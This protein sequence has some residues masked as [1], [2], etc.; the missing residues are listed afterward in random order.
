MLLIR[1]AAFDATIL[2]QRAPSGRRC[3]ISP[4]PCILQVESASSPF[5]ASVSRPCVHP[6]S[7]FKSFRLSTCNSMRLSSSLRTV[8]CNLIRSSTRVLSLDLNFSVVVSI[9][10]CFF[11]APS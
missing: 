6:A 7:A 2:K 5:L 8:A 4:M 1:L 10:I 3:S 9:P 11:P